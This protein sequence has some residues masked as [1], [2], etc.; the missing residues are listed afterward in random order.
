MSQAPNFVQTLSGRPQLGEKI[1]HPDFHLTLKPLW[2]PDHD[3]AEAQV[4]L[5]DSPYILAYYGSQ[6]AVDHYLSMSMPSYGGL[7]YPHTKKDRI[8]NLERMM[9]IT[10][11][12]DD[13]TTNPDVL[14]DQQRQSELRQHYFDAI[15]GIRPPATVPIAQLLYEG[16]LPIKEQLSSKPRVWKR[17]EESLHTMIIRQTDSLALQMDTLTFDRYLELRR[18]DNYGEWAAMMTEYAIDVDMTDAL[19]ADESLATVRTAAIDS[20][21]LVNDPYSFRKEIHIADSVNSVWLLM[22]IEGLTLQ[23]SLDKLAVIVLEN[24]RK[25]IAARDR[26][27]AGPFGKQNDVREYLTELEHLAS[28]NAEFHAISTRYF[29]KD[30][31]GKRFISGEVTIK[32]LPSTDEVAAADI[33]EKQASSATS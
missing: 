9:S 26:V 31:K 17:L 28:G 13:T 25:L 10:T 3:A 2:H 24:E 33:A 1:Y 22:R 15:A 14:A 19:A 27:L 8:Y 11:L 7:A 18:V 12:I 6:K 5:T 16:L 20:I 29:G 4:A 21:T 23:Q 32:P 30:F